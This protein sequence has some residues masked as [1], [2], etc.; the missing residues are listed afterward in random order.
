MKTD[1]E[2]E[3]DELF[4]KGLEDPTRNANFREDDWDAMEALLDQD[5]RRAGIIYWLP[6]A[7]GI[8]AALLLFLGWL[9]LRPNEQPVIVK[10]KPVK[11]VPQLT[12]GQSGNAV[13]YGQQL[14]SGISAAKK[15]SSSTSNAAIPKQPAHSTTGQLANANFAR[16]LSSKTKPHQKLNFDGVAHGRQNLGSA[17][18]S[19]ISNSNL[20]TANLPPVNVA[21]LDANL[22]STDI[23]PSMGKSVLAAP[24]NSKKIKS[25]KTGFKR[26][27][28]A[29]TVLAS[30][31]INGVNSF[32]NSK[33]GT[34][35]G[36]MFSIGISKKFTISTGAV[37][38]KK[39]YLTSFDNYHSN[40]KFKTNPENVTAD[41]RVL[42]IP[43]NL[44]YQLYSRAKNKFSIGSGLSS[45]IMLSEKYHYNYEYPGTVGPTDYNIINRNQHILGV[46][47]LNATYQRQLNSK[48]SIG[49]EPYLKIPLTNIGASQVKLQSTGVA[50]GVTWNINSPP[51]K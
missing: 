34:N 27:N 10:S 25:N 48:I 6:V 22:V 3:L 21:D 50:V 1:R 41:C 39:P 28:L 17:S 33:V 44:D 20:L 19:T 35:A 40:Y 30:P 15:S 32:Q 2:K 11:Q 36:L 49:V 12:Q 9:W 37:Y 24:I 5:Q 14:A 46:L 47:N 38:A 18:E 16:N 45:Y 31:D 23:F 26:P 29:I 42:D 13:T 51:K 4:R 7:G 8:A 43:L